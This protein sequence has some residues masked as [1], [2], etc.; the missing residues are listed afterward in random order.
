MLQC[1][2]AGICVFQCGSV[3]VCLLRRV[4]VLR[5]VFL[6]PK[7]YFSS[8]CLTVCRVVCQSVQ[9]SPCCRFQM[10]VDIMFFIISCLS[11]LD[12]R[13]ALVYEHIVLNASWF[14]NDVCITVTVWP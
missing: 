12:H 1:V 2:T 7:V 13:A 8:E 4:C 5:W 10:I 14:I 9:C 6:C 11:E 3:G